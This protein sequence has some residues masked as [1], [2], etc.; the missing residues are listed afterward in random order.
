MSADE[1]VALDDAYEYLECRDLRHAWTIQGWF[2][3]SDDRM[4]RRLCCMRCRMIRLDTVEG[5]VTKRSYQPP[6]G[7]KLD[8]KVTSAE[9]REEAVSRAKVHKSELDLERSLRRKEA[10]KR[11]GKGASSRRAG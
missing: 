5:W 6:K 7:Y 3:G 1:A 9:I 2:M 11:S 10:S 8:H 4:K